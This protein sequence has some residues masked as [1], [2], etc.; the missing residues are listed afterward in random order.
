MLSP[1]AMRSM[2]TQFARIS[3]VSMRKLLSDTKEAPYSLFRTEFMFLMRQEG[4]SYPQIGKLLG[5]DHTTVMYGVK[6]VKQLMLEN[7][8][9]RREI[10]DIQS[11]LRTGSKS[12][13]RPSRPEPH[14]MNPFRVDEMM[15]NRRV[16]LD[17]CPHDGNSLVREL[18]LGRCPDKFCGYKK[19][20][21][22]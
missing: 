17:E 21:L 14:I 11:A 18:R 3:K 20:L 6:R 1:R 16:A 10:E 22:S 4:V 12:G 19:T 8:R 15:R 9:Y 5:K 7:D 2:L 13:V